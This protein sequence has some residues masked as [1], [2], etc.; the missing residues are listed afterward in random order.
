[1]FNLPAMIAFRLAWKVL[2]PV[3]CR[4]KERE[5]N[6]GD[7]D[8]GLYWSLILVVGD[9]ITNHAAVKEGASNE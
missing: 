9:A 8:D 7:S 6:D 1:M 4:A 2:R 3:I 5:A